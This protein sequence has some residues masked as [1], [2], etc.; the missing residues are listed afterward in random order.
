VLTVPSDPVPPPTPVSS[1]RVAPGPLIPSLTPPGVTRVEAETRPEPVVLRASQRP[2]AAPATIPA[3]P[4]P[5]A[6][7]RPRTPV[8]G[9]VVA[10]R[11]VPPA[12]SDQR[13]TIPAAPLVRALPE[14]VVIAP[15]DQTLLTDDL[16]IEYLDEPGVLAGADLT[17]PCPPVDEDPAPT[18]L[19]LTER[20]ALPIVPAVPRARLVLA[21]PESADGELEVAPASQ[22]RTPVVSQ[23][24]PE[25]PVITEPEPSPIAELARVA[26]AEAAAELEAPEEPEEIDVELLS[27]IAPEV[28]VAAEP[29]PEIE[30]AV[31]VEGK[32]E[33]PEWTFATGDATLHTPP[34]RRA[35][36]RAQPSEV[37]DL[38]GRLGEAP[39]SVDELRTN[40]KH[41]AG[42]DP[43]P[44]PLGVRSND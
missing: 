12:R 42:M 22:A 25:P 7:T 27:E 5:Q 17:E 2:P 13:D 29:E 39:L 20:L 24:E 33:L 38:L 43:T 18:P 26:F 4:P 30:L 31:L 14:S 21:E 41:L 9:T 35:L 11:D 15:H 19:A 44:P 1:A 23:V 37:E 16:E 6:D 34:P 10:V 8:L 36:P 32:D 40:L 28:A 3:P